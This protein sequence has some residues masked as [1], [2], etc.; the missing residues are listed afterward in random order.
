MFVIIR[1]ILAFQLLYSFRGFFVYFPLHIHVYLW[2]YGPH[3]NTNAIHNTVYR[4]SF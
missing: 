3:I 4:A 2:A 1:C